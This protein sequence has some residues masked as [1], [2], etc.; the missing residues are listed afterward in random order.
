M[1]IPKRVEPAVQE[2]K[3][4]AGFMNMFGGDAPKKEPEVVK[5]P[6]PPPAQ[7]KDS[8]INTLFGTGPVPVPRTD[9]QPVKS[10]VIPKKEMNFNF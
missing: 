10:P 4:T 9:V 7:S 1:N 2:Q 5:Q 8:N 6:T 3:K